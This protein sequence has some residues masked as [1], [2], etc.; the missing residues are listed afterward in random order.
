MLLGIGYLL[1]YAA[2]TSQGQYARRPW[3]AMTA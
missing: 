2:V 3:K 1:L